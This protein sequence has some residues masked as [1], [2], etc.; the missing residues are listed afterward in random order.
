MPSKGSLYWAL[1]IHADFRF[2][3]LHHF[4][5]GLLIFIS[6]T[7][8]NIVDRGDTCVS[9]MRIVVYRISCTRAVFNCAHEPYWTEHQMKIIS[10]R[11]SISKFIC[12]FVHMLYSAASARTCALMLI[13]LMAATLFLLYLILYSSTLIISSKSHSFSLVIGFLTKIRG[14]ERSERERESCSP[15]SSNSRRSV[16]RL[17][18]D[19]I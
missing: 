5:L 18:N 12:S 10:V 9:S 4:S 15:N 11:S 19:Y 2:Q 16:R 13:L 7:F 14:R 3:A 1:I 8:Y 6:Y 17:A